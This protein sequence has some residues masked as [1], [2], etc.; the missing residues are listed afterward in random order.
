MM[1]HSFVQEMVLQERCDAPFVVSYAGF[2]RKG[3]EKN[4]L[5]SH[6]HSTKHCNENQTVR[7]SNE[8]KM[9]WTMRKTT[10]RMRFQGEVWI[11]IRGGES[12]EQS[13]SVKVSGMTKS[14]IQTAALLRASCSWQQHIL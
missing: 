9:Q 12:A 1:P 3:R 13:A 8:G 4:Y 6:F 14:V 11:A 7:V 10:K 2:T 5:D